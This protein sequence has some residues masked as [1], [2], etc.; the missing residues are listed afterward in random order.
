MDPSR[1]MLTFE[2][3]TLEEYDNCSSD[4][5]DEL[6]YGVVGLSPSGIV[7]IYNAT[8]ARLA[9]LSRDTVIGANFFLGIAQCMNNFMVAQRL[10][11]EKEIDALIDYVLTFRMRP[12]PVRIRLLKK[13][14]FA[15]RYVLIER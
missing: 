9:G 7:E 15:H 3:G 1:Q 6:A 10:E 13:P 11:D 8:E 4:R 14:G 2:H 12:T 5:L